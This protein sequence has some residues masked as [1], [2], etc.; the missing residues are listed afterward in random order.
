MHFFPQNAP[1]GRGCDRPRLVFSASRGPRTSL[2]SDWQR[3]VL[4]ASRFEN[5]LDF[6]AETDVSTIV[7]FEPR[8]IPSPLIPP[9]FAV[10]QFRALALL[11][12]RL[13]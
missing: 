8:R 1:R 12:L 4:A 7:V 9:E 2:S 5:W 11:R 6:R 13:E 10:L 3:A